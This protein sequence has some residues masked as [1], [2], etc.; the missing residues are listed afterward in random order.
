MKNI[1]KLTNQELQDKLVN[2][3]KWLSMALSCEPE[4]PKME[5]EYALAMEEMER[6]VASWKPAQI[7]AS[8]VLAQK[9]K[10]VK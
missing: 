2:L 6:R 1:T 9:S 4:L 10:G 3:D 5:K 7:F 8:V